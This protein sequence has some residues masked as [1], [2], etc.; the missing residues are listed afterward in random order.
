MKRIFLLLLL[1]AVQLPARQLA[2]PH[3]LTPQEKELLKTYVPPQSIRGNSFPP[4]SPVRAMAEWEELHGLMITW[5]SYYDILAQIVDYAQEEVTVYIVCSDSNQVKYYLQNHGVELKNLKFLIENY[6]TVWCRD[7]GP[8]T[9]YETGA[10]TL[11]IIDWIYN[12][13]RPNDD[14]IPSEFAAYM[15]L[16]EYEA[17]QTPDDLT[18]TG[19]N[20]MV[21]GHGT[22]FSS[23]LILDENSGKTEAEIDDIMNRYLG[24]TRYIKMDVLPYDEIHHIDMHMKLL[25]EETLLVGQYPDGVAD[26]PQIEANLQYVLDNFSTCYGRDYEVV[27]IPMPPDAAGRY[28][29][30]GGD[31][32]TYTNSVIVNHTVIVPTYEEQ[33]DTTALRIYRQAMPGY[34]VVGIDCNEIITALGAIHCITKEVGVRNPLLISHA[35]IRHAYDTELT[36]DVI[37]QITTN[38]GVSS[39]ALFWSV[40]T[41]QGFT[42]QAMTTAANDSFYAEIPGQPA[43]TEVFYYIS[44]ASNLGKTITKPLVAPAGVYT[45]TVEQPSAVAGA[46]PQPTGTFRLEANYPNPFNPYTAISYQLSAFSYV[47]LTVYNALGRKVQTLVNR[48]QA[49]GAYRVTFDGSGLASGVYF[50]RLQAGSFVQVR[51]MIFLR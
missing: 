38:S 31:Y 4:P 17:T 43:G 47:Q 15:G 5:T 42:Q 19:G 22:G 14:V 37:A 44:A 2:H 20:F 27:R 8:W 32:R 7:Y 48:N 46:N 23:K 26:G 36:Y 50:Y 35:A 10:D 49:A 24:L 3:Y 51:K 30:E 40:D 6:D 13:P 21:D 41:T 9:A 12:R 45:F 34:N 28:P 33:Y 11:D 29:D 39:A 18:H 1:M 16:P 25:D